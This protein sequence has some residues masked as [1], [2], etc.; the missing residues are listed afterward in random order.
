MKQPV[1]LFY[2]LLSIVSFGQNPK[3]AEQIDTPTELQLATFGGGCFWC[4]EAVF[5]SLKGVEQVVSG[6][7]G[8]TIKN[9][10]Y[11]DVNTGLSGHAEV[12]QIHFNPNIINYAELLEIFWSTHDPTTPNQQGADIGP[13]Y[14]SVI[15]YHN[16]EQKKQAQMYRKK[17][18]ASGAFDA[19]IVTEIKRALTFYK[20]EDFHQNYYALHPTVPYCRNVIAP[21]LEKLEKVFGDKLKR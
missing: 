18:N 15:F 19:P 2:L 6:Y 7:S 3:Q 13:Q 12:V 4:T 10:T 16:K 9:P 20:A 8:G 11:K 5:L 14:R 21:K 17:L 1:Y